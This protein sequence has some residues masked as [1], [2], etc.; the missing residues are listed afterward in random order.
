[1]NILLLPKY[2]AFESACVKLSC[3]EPSAINKKQ[4]L[5]LIMPAILMIIEKR[6]RDAV[7]FLLHETYSTNSKKVSVTLKLIKRVLVAIKR[8]DGIGFKVLN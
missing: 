5:F 7:S 3:I 4:T 1:M 6:C 8:G 2:S